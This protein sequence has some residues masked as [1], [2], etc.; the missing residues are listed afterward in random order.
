MSTDGLVSGPHLDGVR[1]QHLEPHDDS[2]GVFTEVFCD[3]WGTGIDPVQWSVVQ[4]AAGV[5]RGMHFHL[6]HEELMTVVAGHLSVGLYDAREG[7]PTEGQAG[8]YVL[9]GDRPALI[10]FPAGIVHGLLFHER[11]IHLQAVTEASVHYA[12]DDNH[13]CHWSDPALG[14][15]WPFEPTILS[16]RQDR[17]PALE[18]MLDRAGRARGS[19]HPPAGPSRTGA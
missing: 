18:V 19:V 12:A 11:S 16:D 7:S 9:S 4:S 17:Y 3:H 2:R 13:G 15:D 8:L 1:F 5:L 10:S 14:I 6:R